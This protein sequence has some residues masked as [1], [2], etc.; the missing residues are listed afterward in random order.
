VFTSFLYVDEDAD[1][2]YS[3]GVLCLNVL[4]APLELH[5]LR[6]LLWRNHA[7]VQGLPEKG[8]LDL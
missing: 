8:A 3:I 2:L 4:P 7:V 5:Q 1:P 6:K